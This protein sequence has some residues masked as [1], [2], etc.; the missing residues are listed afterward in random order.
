MNDAI[1]KIHSS[2]N[3]N[4]G[5]GFVFKNT[6]NAS[7]ILTCGHVIKSIEA[8]LLANDK[9]AEI[10]YSAYESGLDLAVL[11]T[12]KIDCIP[13]TLSDSSDLKS[14]TVTGY[15]SL[16]KGVKKE[17]ITINDAKKI[18]YCALN[19]GNEHPS[20][21]LYPNEKISLGYSGSPVLKQDG[22]V[23]GIV[24]LASSDNTNYALCIEN[25]DLLIKDERILSA[26][27]H[28]RSIKKLKSDISPEKIS[29][30][31]FSLSNDY[32]NSLRFLSTVNDINVEPNLYDCNEYGSLKSE[33]RTKTPI[34]NLV[35]NAEC[36][37]IY[38]RPQY[39]LTVLAKHIC[40]KSFN[41]EER[42]FWLYLDANEIKP[43][44]KE[45]LDY[46][47]SKLSILDLKRE[48]IGCI[49]LDE[50][51]SKLHKVQDIID[52]IS[53]LFKE[54]PL[55]IMYTNSE[56]VDMP[57]TINLPQDRSFKKLYLWPLT[58]ND[59]RNLVCSYNEKN[60]ISDEDSVVNRIVT[61]LDVLNM[62]RTILNCLTILRIYEIEF[63]DS[64][65]NRTEMIRRVL[66]LLFNTDSIPS[67]KTKPDLK[68]TEYVLGYY[69]ELLIKNHDT[70]FLRQHFLDEIRA[71]CSEHEI[72]LDTDIIFDTLYEN[73][74]IVHYRNKY[75]FKFTYW[76][77]YF[78]AQRM[79]QS[80][81]FAKFIFDELNYISYPEVIEFYTGIDRRRD[82]ALQHINNDLLEIIKTTKSR[83][84]FKHD[85]DIYHNARWEPSQAMIEK[86]N[87]DISSEV[88]DS[89]LPIEFKDQYADKQYNHCRP[90]D[91]QV[92]RILDEYSVLRLMK[93]TSAASKALRNSDYTTPKIR[94]ELLNTILLS[95]RQLINIL[96]VLSP[97]MAY[98]RKASIEGAT[99]ILDNSFKDADPWQTFNEVLTS[100][101][102]NVVSWYKD[103]LF[104]KKMSSLIYKHYD[105]KTDSLIKHAMITL[106]I[107]KRPKDWLNK[108]SD[109]ISI[110][111]KNSFYLRDIHLTLRAE[112]KYGFI[113]NE[114]LSNLELLIKSI[115]AKH[116]LGVKNP[117]T[118]VISKVRDSALPERIE[119]N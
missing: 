20:L 67:Y 48:D 59:I 22:S 62:P 16:L 81:E 11:K 13:L 5:T 96:V 1:V 82:N 65:I 58:R 74:I 105:E 19:D 37:V 31:N 101:P 88:M 76:I 51:T 12:D 17:S 89:K 75:R 106:I 80:D 3:T 84:G 94:H 86:M 43:Y 79:H 7:F 56:T 45:I 116:T 119:D 71:F 30:I 42:S 61:D 93:C 27:L 10:I 38:G 8:S 110:V 28:R 90:L 114:D 83:F 46:I 108:V 2:A 49:V 25:L 15:T 92:H 103:D 64:P 69:C 63:D 99:F 54:I 52:R 44:D 29:S 72:D 40:L 41:A 60:Y 70:T 91:Q 85:F 47:D 73:N 21:R 26:G 66:S 87:D 95:W 6:E 77:Y 111:H 23:V 68:D 35:N 112:Y 55:I 32:R 57:S 117:G 107:Q 18:N 104:S 36:T 115:V 53:V 113:S 34:N 39:G 33:L 24:I 102:S 118:K 100:L 4:F 50:V 97:I 9:A 98:N 14:L 78:V 109:Y